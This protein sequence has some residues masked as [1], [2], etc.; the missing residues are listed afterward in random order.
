METKRARS[1]PRILLLDIETAP[2]VVW[3]W[4]V[5]QENAIAVK[6]HWYILSI[7][8]AWFG[9]RG[10]T[11]WLGLCDTK[12]GGRGRNGEKELLQTVW[13]LLDEADIV[14]AHNGRDFDV[15]KLNARMIEHRM[16]PPSHYKVIDTK[17][18]LT[19]VAR[20]SSNRLNWLCKQLGIGRK[21]EEHHD[22]KMWEG[23]MNGEE[24]MW[25]RMKTYNRH[26]VVLLREL[27]KVLSAWIVQPNANLWSNN[28]RC[29]NPACSSRKM[30]G[31]GTYVANSRIYQR[32]RCP[33]CGASARSRQ[34]IRGSSPSLVPTPRRFA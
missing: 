25:R 18:D 5:Y 26:D 23:C 8:W 29:V 31:N 2:D 12:A 4:G 27:Y 20:F 19:P 32:Y 34:S 11:E 30:H 28:P 33:Q 7:S 1:G 22:W 24:R 14:L 17:R 15:R 10:K 21:T 16:P 13:K 3:T 6:E 9:E